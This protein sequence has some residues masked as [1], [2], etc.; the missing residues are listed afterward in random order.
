MGMVKEEVLAYLKENFEMDPEDAAGLIGE[1]VET[2]DGY[3]ARAEEL[4]GSGDGWE[5]LGRIGHTIK[6]TSANVGANALRDAGRE[7][8]LGG[9]EMNVDASRAANAKIKMLVNELR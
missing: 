1:F 3:V 9:K 6:G 8:E 4:L 7:L 5:E 2:I